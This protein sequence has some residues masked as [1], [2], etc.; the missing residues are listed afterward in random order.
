[1][2]STSIENFTPYQ[3]FDHAIYEISKILQKRWPFLYLN[4]T[5]VSG[6][7]PEK[8]LMGAKDNR[9]LFVKSVLNVILKQIKYNYVPSRSFPR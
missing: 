8:K 6:F 2:L 1:M 7:A 3:P 4:F 9:P 5:R